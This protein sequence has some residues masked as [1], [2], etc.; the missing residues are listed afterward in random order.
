LAAQITSPGKSSGLSLSKKKSVQPY[1]HDSF[2]TRMN[3]RPGFAEFFCRI[4]L[5]DSAR[6]N[7]FQAARIPPGTPLGEGE[8]G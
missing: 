7:Y 8:R 3:W 1:F 2:D 5:P 6:G 4:P